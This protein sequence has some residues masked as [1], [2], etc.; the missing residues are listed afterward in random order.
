MPSLSFTQ[1]SYKLMF[2]QKAAQVY[3]NFIHNYLNLKKKKKKQD[4]LGQLNA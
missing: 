2:P 4:V 1:M 3:A